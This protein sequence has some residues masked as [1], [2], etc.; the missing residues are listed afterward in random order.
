M[1]DFSDLQGVVL[2]F[3]EALPLTVNRPGNAVKV[4]GRRVDGPITP[5]TGVIG[6]CWPV[7]GKTITLLEKMGKRIT[8]GI[9]I[10]TPFDE[11]QIADDE[12]GE[13]GDRVTHH[14]KIYEIIVRHDWIRGPLWH[15]TARL[16]RA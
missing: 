5:V 15:Y 16:V 4:N 11:L 9:D 6:S 13:V 10:F 3:A 12:T 14:G 7:Q 1:I 8:A 2:D